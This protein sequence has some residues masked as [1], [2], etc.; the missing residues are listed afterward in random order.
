MAVLHIIYHNRQHLS[1]TVRHNLRVFSLHA[2]PC[3]SNLLLDRTNLPAK[4]REQGCD[5]GPAAAPQG[6]FSRFLARL[7]SV[8]VGLSLCPSALGE[9]FREVLESDPQPVTARWR[10][11][12]GA[13][14]SS[15]F[16]QISGCCLRVAG[17][18]CNFSFYHRID[19]TLTTHH[20]RGSETYYCSHSTT[21]RR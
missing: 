20:G 10:A 6:G 17:A 9:L 3:P 19:R 7:V 2:G 5:S 4:K 12:S 8:F 13:L 21:L 16:L 14:L 11:G 1:C 18:Q 15:T